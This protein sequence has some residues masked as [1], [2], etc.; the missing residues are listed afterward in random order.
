VNT[1]ISVVLIAQ[2]EQERI[3]TAIRTC[4]LFA[5]EILVIDGGSQDNTVAEAERAGARVVGNSW[6]GYAKQRN[7]GDSLAANDWIFFLDADEEVDPALASALIVWKAQTQNP[8]HA[9]AVNR[10][11]NFLSSWLYAAAEKKV[12]LYHRHV[13]HIIETE[14][15]ETP[16]APATAVRLLDGIIWHRGFRSIDDHVRRFNRYTD[17]EAGRDARVERHFSLWRLLTRPIARFV[18]QYLY[19]QLC[20]YGISGLAVAY[21]WFLYEVLRELKLY[22]LEWRAKAP[23]PMDSPHLQ[24][25]KRSAG[26]PTFALRERSTADGVTASD[27][28]GSD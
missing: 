6:P 26:P 18:H 14:V 4:S 1:R 17:L 21:L 13:Y 27:C 20:R 7:Y 16:N 25:R 11:G 3:V 10:I 9:F 2:N 5:D 19:C 28:D 15:H 22:E 24:R 12:R 23:A 8:K